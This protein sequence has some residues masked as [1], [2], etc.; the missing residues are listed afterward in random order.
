[1]KE[2]LREKKE[3]KAVKIQTNIKNVESDLKDK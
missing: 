2:H 1:M 3:E